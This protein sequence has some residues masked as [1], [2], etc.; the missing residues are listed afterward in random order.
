M[1]YQIPLPPLAE[2][3]RIV[4][5]IEELAAKVEEAHRLRSSATA[6][7]QSLPEAEL[8]SLFAHLSQRHGLCGLERLLVDAGYGTSVKCEYEH[9]DEMYPVLRIPN[10]ASETV[11]FEDLKYAR[12]EEREI[13]RVALFNDDLLLVRTNGSADLVGRCAV[14]QELREPTAFA[15]Y[16]IRLRFN[17]SSVAPDYVQRMLRHLRGDGQLFDFARTTAGQ[18]NISLGR[19]RAA[20]FPVPPLEEQHRIVA[21]L[22][23]LQAKVDGL[24]QLQAQTAAELDALLPSILDK[25]F[26]GEL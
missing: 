6:C 12:L 1:A 20:Q 13:R 2:Q 22:D 3:R 9:N 8:S 21:Y 5:S 14:V 26:K 11:T 24:K 10:I 15:S 25:A 16:L 19:L 4:A 17:Q 18:Y 7:G 23:E